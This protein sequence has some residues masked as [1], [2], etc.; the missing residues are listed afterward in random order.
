MFRDSQSAYEVITLHDKVIFNRTGRALK[1]IEQADMPSIDAE[2]ILSANITGNAN[3]LGATN[4]FIVDGV[5]Y[6]E[7]KNGLYSNLVEHEGSG[8]FPLDD[9]E[10]YSVEVRSDGNNVMV[11]YFKDKQYKRIIMPAPLID[12]AR[13][14]AYDDKWVKSMSVLIKELIQQEA[15]S[16]LKSIG[17]PT[18]SKAIVTD[19][20]LMDGDEFYF[21]KVGKD[22]GFIPVD[23]LRMMSKLDGAKFKYSCAAQGV[24]PITSVVIDGTDERLIF[25]YSAKG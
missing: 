13:L 24:L 4:A 16:I 21:K 23:L 6:A 18:S 9:E 8:V 17:R 3:K 2:I 12:S 19:G 25:K 20:I 11:D 15:S 7:F 14:S 10:K 1:E 22:F 5:M